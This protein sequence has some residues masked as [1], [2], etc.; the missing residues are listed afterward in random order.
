MPKGIPGSRSVCS[1]P[2]CDAPQQARDWCASHYQSQ[3]MLTYQRPTTAACAVDGCDK[4]TVGRGLCRPHYG[5]EWKRHRQEWRAARDAARPAGCKVPGCQRPLHQSSARGYCQMHYQR[6]RQTGTPG[7]AEAVRAP[8]GSGSVDKDGYYIFYV[9]GRKYF[10]HRYVMEQHLGR[11]L[12]P[13]ENVHHKNGLK[14]DNRIG[15]LELWVGW[16]KQPSGQRVADLIAFM[17]ERYPEQ[18]AAALE[19]GG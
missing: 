2:G 1:V 16:G 5:Q 17:V 4:P 19:A 7:P 10:E 14:R 15:N 9:D 8:N 13:E 3:Y 18:V 11:P 12:L 6:W